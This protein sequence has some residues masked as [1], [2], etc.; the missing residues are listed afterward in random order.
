MQLKWKW[1]SM[2]GIGGRKRGAEM[3]HI[4]Y[5]CRKFSK[6]TMNEY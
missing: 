4:Q 1:K 5:I 3:M 2:G 6:I